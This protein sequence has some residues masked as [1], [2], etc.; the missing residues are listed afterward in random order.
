MH[1]PP[2]GPAAC[3]APVPCMPAPLHPGAPHAAPVACVHH[4]HAART[5]T[6]ANSGA[7][8]CVRATNPCRGRRMHAAHWPR[9]H[10][11]R[12]NKLKHS[13]Q[14]SVVSAQQQRSSC[15]QV[16]HNGGSLYPHP[17]AGHARPRRKTSD[18]VLL[19]LSRV[20]MKPH[21]LM[22]AKHMQTKAKSATASL[23]ITNKQWGTLF[24]SPN[25]PTGEG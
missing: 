4:A 7:L 23:N 2:G 19:C 18:R 1:G 6:Q 10:R 24:R 20:V 25:T 3:P 21:A 17:I 8:C 16:I 22:A 5:I 13:L 11:I 9:A 15:P 14:P 12:S